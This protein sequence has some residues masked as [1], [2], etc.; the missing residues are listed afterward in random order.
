MVDIDER[1]VAVYSD[2]TQ[3]ELFEESQSLTGGDILP[4]LTI[5]LSALFGELDRTRPSQ[6]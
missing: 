6:S 5:S 3:H 2:I 1:T 4:G